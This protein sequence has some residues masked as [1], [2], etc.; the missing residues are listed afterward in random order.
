[1]TKEEIY[2][3]FHDHMAEVPHLGG[4]HVVYELSPM[5][6]LATVQSLLALERD[7]CATVCDEIGKGWLASHQRVK[8]Y[9]ANDLA[10]LIRRLK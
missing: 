6:L 7:R 9:A 5:E 3:A 4:S 10:E 8:S 2:L 1:M